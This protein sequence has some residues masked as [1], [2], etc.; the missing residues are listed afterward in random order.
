MYRAQSRD[1]TLLED[2]LEGIGAPLWVRDSNGNVIGIRGYEGRTHGDASWSFSAQGLNVGAEWTKIWS[3][4]DLNNFTKSGEFNS[5]YPA[6]VTEI[7]RRE[8]NAM[9]IMGS[10]MSQNY[11]NLTKTGLSLNLSGGVRLGVLVYCHRINK[12]APG[13]IVLYLGTGYSTSYKY[14]WEWD[15]NTLSDG[16]NFLP[17]HTY[18]TGLQNSVQ[19]GGV[20]ADGWYNTATASY[21]LGNASYFDSTTVTY[22]RIE[23]NGPKNACDPVM[24]LEGVYRDGSESKSLITI[25]FDISNATPLAT[26]K[27]LMDAQG[28]RGYAAAPTANG[29]PS[30]PTYAWSAND[31]AQMLALYNAGWDIIG[32]SVSHNSLGSM[33][34]A[35]RIA[36][37]FEMNRQQMLRLGMRRGANFFATP[38]GSYSPR[39]QYELARRGCVWNRNI[40][41]APILHYDSFCGVMNPMNIGSLKIT[42]TPSVNQSYVDL[43]LLYKA[44]INFYCHAPDTAGEPSSSTLATFFAYVKT[45]Q[46]AGLCE[47]LTPSEKYYRVHTPRFADVSGVPSRHVLTPG[48]SPFAY[49]NLGLAP[50]MISV[51]GGTVS[52]ISASRDNSTYDTT[53]QTAGMF[54]VEPGDYLKVTYT[55]VPTMVQ[56]RI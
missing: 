43:A 36:N 10:Q 30:N 9:K 22:C 27:T 14:K 33:T 48:A 54:R 28:F 45:K 23:F 49:Q 38:N 39:V 52:D 32:H 17:V 13:N 51:S 41:N 1:G 15:T 12:S 3:A 26:L 47:V 40:Q 53:G 42:D 46:D 35:E 25:G 44:N 29:D 16:W 8:G 37:E 34:D 56:L 55:V 11:G 6:N 19:T 7:F 50:V 2:Q 31:R 4:N 21:D 5:P 24:Y 18:D 20:Y